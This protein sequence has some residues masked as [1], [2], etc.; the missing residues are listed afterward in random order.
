MKWFFVNL[1]KFIQA[2]FSGN[3]DVS[4]KRVNGTFCIIATVTLIVLFPIFKWELSDALKSLIEMI[5]WG[6]TMLLGLGIAD[7]FF[8]N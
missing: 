7:R 8:K 1:F 3:S 2:M 4:S 5:F 6:G